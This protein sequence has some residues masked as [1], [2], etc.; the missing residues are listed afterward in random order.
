MGRP[1]VSAAHSGAEI[2]HPLHVR[3]AGQ[4]VCLKRVWTALAGFFVVCLGLSL[5]SAQN[6]VLTHHNDIARTGQNL[7]ETLLTPANVN[8]NHFGKLFTQNVDGIVVGQP[9]YAS[10]VL[11]GDGLVHNVVFVVT[12][13]NT[14]YAFD[15]DSNQAPIW[16]VSL[17][18][19]GTPDPIGDF[20]C[21]GT[22]F[23]EIGITSTPVIDAG[24]TTV[25]VVAKTLTGDVRAFNL[26]ALDIQTG[27]DILGGPTTI[28]GSYGSDTFDVLLQLQRPALLLDSNGLIYIGFGGN[29]CDVYDY[30]GWLFVYN[31]QTLQQQAVFETAPNGKKSSIWQGGAG[32]S[33]DEFGSIYVVTANGTYDGPTGENDFGD[34]VLKIGWN[35]NA[36]GIQDY[37]TPYNQQY[38]QEND[39]DLGSAG[40]LILPDQPG[41]YPHELVAGGKAGTLYLVNRDDLGEYNTTYDDVIQEISGF[42]FELTGDPS[43]WN[44]SVYVAGDR[45]YIK[46]FL[47]V[48]G[49]LVTPPLSQTSVLF[50]GEGAASISITANG[51]SNGVL[52]ALE[53]S[54]HI[55]YAFDPTN[56]AN[57]LYNS[58]QALHS[59]DTLGELIRFATPTVSKGKVYVGGKS[60]LTVYGLLPILS[61]AGGNGQIGTP[62]EVLP[63]AL[64]VLASNAYTQ[65]PVSGLSVTCNDGKAGGSFIGGATQTTDSTGTA[66]FQYQLPAT[67]KAVTITCSNPGTASATFSETCAAEAPASLSIVSGNNQIAPPNTP[68][69][70]PFVVRVLDANGNVVPGVMVTFT[71]NGAGGSFSATSPKTNSA[72][73]AR[74]K[75]T[76]GPNT[77]AVTVTA[78]VPSVNSVNFTVTVQ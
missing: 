33:V 26:H 40:A 70:K 31:S 32:P 48:N 74:T 73:I 52:W 78:S 28:A 2:A 29:G 68:L 58:K 54:A 36:L 51:S 44:G 7:N 23:T 76:T 19:G 57:E 21:K 55:L 13:N 39:L 14:V 61:A 66:T 42:P 43:Y 53:H 8:I 3:A 64:S 46:Q 59:R 77:G 41:M 22:G 71:D 60:A 30:N 56:L 49:T 16:S 34:S 72:G 75:Y 37:F 63:I 6:D 20:G 62:G 9:L 67:P 25:Y 69:G 10:N 24:K 38:L 12:Q 18:D 50:G 17:D 35:G 47:L 15:A 1:V 4:I 45:D 5:A 65:A 11:M 27:A